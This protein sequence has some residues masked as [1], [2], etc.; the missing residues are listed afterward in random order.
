M[1]VKIIQNHWLPKKLNVTAITL[2]PRIYLSCDYETAINQD[3]INHEFIH[4]RQI[5]Q[6]GWIKFYIV[7]LYNYITLYLKL[8]NQNDAYMHIPAEI[9]AYSL[10][11]SIRYPEDVKLVNGILQET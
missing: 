8:K 3:V 6:L 1:K 11:A 4:V 2:Y 7:Y 10:Q 5:R 9:E